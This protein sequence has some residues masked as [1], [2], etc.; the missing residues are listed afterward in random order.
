LEV[1]HIQSRSSLGNDVEENLITLCDACHSKIHLRNSETPR[2]K[3]GH[4]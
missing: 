3:R 4:R 2:I 1:H